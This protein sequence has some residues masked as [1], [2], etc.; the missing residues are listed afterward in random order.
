MAV[1]ISQACPSCGKLRLVASD[2]PAPLCRKC[3]KRTR[4]EARAL[5]VNCTHCGKGFVVETKGKAEYYKETGI[6]YCSRICRREHMRSTRSKVMAETNR[7]CA[8]ERM[9]KRNPMK[10]ASSR[11]KMRNTLRK[12]H[13]RP[14]QQGGNGRP[15][16]G[17]QAALAGALSWPTE[18]VVRT[19]MPR[20]SGYPTCYKL[21]IANRRL[22]VA[23]EVD[24]GS[25]CSRERQEQDRRKDLFLSGRGW[26]VLRFSNQEVTEHLADCVRT[27][28]STTLR[29]LP[30]TL[31]SP[32]DSSSTIVTTSQPTA[33]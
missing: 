26:T 23:I 25:H 16:S 1:A 14:A 9:R 22:K 27:V 28:L 29:S 8:S 5:K 24:G 18:V 13:H 20:G 21:D 33:S 10:V 6:A 15:L 19:R 17:P 11:E 3:A 2:K 7:R 30:T 32:T 4:A 31:T 12:I